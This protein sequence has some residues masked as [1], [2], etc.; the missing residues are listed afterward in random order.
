MSHL[1][2]EVRVNKNGVAVTKH[3]LPATAAKTK[4]SL[5][6]PSAVPSVGNRLPALK[7]KVLKEAKEY[8]RL[9]Q[10]G[11]QDYED[12]MTAAFLDND[13][14][15]M[16]L[17]NGLTKGGTYSSPDSQFARDLIDVRRSL[18]LGDDEDDATFIAKCEKYVEM[19]DDRGPVISE[20]FYMKTRSEASNDII[21]W[22]EANWDDLDE[23]IEFLDG[24]QMDDYSAANFDAL[25]TAYKDSSS[26]KPLSDGII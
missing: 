17:Y 12:T 2:P 21:R 20:D 18:G 15:F 14:R 25:W 26:V 5:P 10:N 6:A 4:A 22:V 7:G 13:I 16:R 19:A 1:I 23:I 8:V 3:V 11:D 9:A 24:R